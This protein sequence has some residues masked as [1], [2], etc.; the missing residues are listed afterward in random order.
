MID[1]L[2][3]V[4]VAAGMLAAVNPCGF[5]LLPAYLGI[6]VWGP[7]GS[8]GAE[9][10]TG[11]ALLRA[12]RASLALGLGFVALFT[13]FGLVIAP[14]AS[15]LQQHL[16]WFT[17]FFGLVLAAMGA[18]L[19]VRGELPSLPRFGSGRRTPRPLSGS[20]W[21]I[22]AFGAGYAAA[23]LTC[24]IAPFLAVVVAGARAR[25]FGAGLSLYAGYG[26]GMAAVVAAVSVAV[27][28]AS[29]GFVG[30]ARRAGR[31]VPRVGGVLALLAGAYVAY[32]G[33]W[34][35]RVLAGEAAADPVI[36]AAAAVQR[37]L[38]EVVGRFAPPYR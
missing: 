36:D 3:A 15:G 28:L 27:A 19:L 12:L 30:R 7:A 14:V 25:S 37:W 31:W 5:A 33:W 23:S 21:S 10:G 1:G 32:Y 8:A 35:L 13:A 34:E 29:T 9:S 16:P 38:A 20:F 11:R 4:A 26:L 17:V 24:T 22:L 2:F 6:F 18:V